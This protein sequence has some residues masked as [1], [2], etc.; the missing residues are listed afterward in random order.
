M[1]KTESRVYKSEENRAKM[2]PDGTVSKNRWGVP[3]MLFSKLWCMHVAA[4]SVPCAK[5]SGPNMIAITVG[6]MT[7]EL[8]AFSE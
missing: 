6:I 1:G 3:K 4:F 7:P 8:H 5:T 2:R